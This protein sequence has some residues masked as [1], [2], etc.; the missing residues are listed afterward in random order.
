MEKMKSDLCL[1]E[2]CEK[3][4]VKRGMCERHYRNALEKG[5]ISRARVIGGTVKDRLLFHSKHI[6]DTGC[7]EWTGSFHKETEYG[8]IN[9]NGKTFST[10]RTAWEEA[11][12][13]IPK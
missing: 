5:I 6:P 2:G 9:I 3:K 11:N 10:H 7:R 13:P 12:G 8:N 4:S 1:K